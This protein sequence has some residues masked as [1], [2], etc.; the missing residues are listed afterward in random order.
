[1]IKTLHIPDA[2]FRSGITGKYKLLINDVKPKLGCYEYEL[3]DAEGKEYKAIAK[4]HYAKDQ[5]LRSIVSFQ[6]VNARLVVSE[7]VVCKKQDMATLIP[8]PPKPQ[9]KPDSKPVSKS[10]EK[11]M[12]PKQKP[13]TKKTDGKS[14]KIVLGDPRHR[15]TSGTYVFRVAEVTRND[16]SYSY[17]VE[18]AGQ[19]LYEVQSRVS[20][21]VGTFVDC[22][23][24]V[25]SSAGGIL[26][27]FVLSI[28]EHVSAEVKPALHRKSLNVLK[29]WRSDT[30]SHDTFS[31]P[32][33]GDHFHII[34]TPMGNKR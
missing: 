22:G 8:E 20:F 28:K 19:Q 26:K 11:S 16:T 18:G 31:G 30:K 34:Y 3:L 12:K 13:A 4:E 21:P 5:L 33:P 10:K 9:S 6:V 27:V 23:V 29:H 25:S 17:K 14:K 24:K 7:V 15:H 32:N 1:M 2:P